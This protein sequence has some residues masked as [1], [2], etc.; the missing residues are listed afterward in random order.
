MGDNYGPRIVTREPLSVDALRDKT[1]AV[2]GLMTTAY[3]GLQLLLG[4]DTFTP[5]VVMFDEI[6]DAVA[7]GVVDAGLLIH[8]GQLTYQQQGLHLVVDPGAVV[9]GERPACRCRWGGNIIRRDLGPETCRE[10]TGIMRKSIQYSLDNRKE[11]VKYALQFGRGLDEQLAD[12]FVGMY[13]N[14]WTLDY[15]PRRGRGGSAAAG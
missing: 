10:V 3:L 7:G 6:P 9:D 1:I 13:V 2:P 12:E 14:K 15:G 11:A 4:K 8:E 5:K